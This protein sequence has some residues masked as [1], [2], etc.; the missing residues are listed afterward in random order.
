[1]LLGINPFLFLDQLPIAVAQ[2]RVDYGHIV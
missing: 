1:M 2:V